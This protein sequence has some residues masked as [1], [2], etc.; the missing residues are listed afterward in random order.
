VASSIAFDLQGELDIDSSR[1]V[2]SLNQVARTASNIFS[3]V[4]FKEVKQSMSAMQKEMVA[5]AKKT[6]KKER[7][8]RNKTRC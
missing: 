4:N 8:A 7:K 2:N 3:G 6:R 5:E 1:A